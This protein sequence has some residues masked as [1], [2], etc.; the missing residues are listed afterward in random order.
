[1]EF[2]NQY[3]TQPMEFKV[4]KDFFRC[5]ERDFNQ[6]KCRQR[7]I[8]QETVDLGETVDDREPAI[9]ILIKYVCKY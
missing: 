1:M 7:S 3:Q 2:K 5:G 9:Y 6:S 8:Y 4:R